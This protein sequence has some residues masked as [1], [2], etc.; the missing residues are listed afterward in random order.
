MFSVEG[1]KVKRILTNEFINNSSHSAGCPVIN[2]NEFWTLAIALI[3]FYRSHFNSYP[4][5][6]YQSCT[7]YFCQSGDSECLW[8]DAP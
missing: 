5:Y 1:R 8:T 4:S 7:V 3:Y 6:D 2:A